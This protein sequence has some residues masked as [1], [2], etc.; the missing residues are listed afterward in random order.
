MVTDFAEG[1][2]HLRYLVGWTEALVASV[3]AVL[4]FGAGDPVVWED[5]PGDP[6]HGTSN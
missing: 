1:Q 2:N 3:R 6:A 5:G 4:T